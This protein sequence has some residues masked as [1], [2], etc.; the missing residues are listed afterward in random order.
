MF[1]TCRFCHQAIFSTTLPTERVAFVADDGWGTICGQ[2]P[3]GVSEHQASDL[4]TIIDFVP[5]PEIDVPL[6]RVAR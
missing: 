1:S 3:E 4:A 2:A 6:Q 5:V